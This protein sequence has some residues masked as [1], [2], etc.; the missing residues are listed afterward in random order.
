MDGT[1]EINATNSSWCQCRLILESQK[2]SL[3]AE[4]LLY[5]TSHLLSALEK[6][7]QGYTGEWRGHKVKWVLTLADQHST[8]Y[9]ASEGEHLILL[10]Q[11]STTELIASL[12]L[13]VDDCALWR[14]EIQ[15]LY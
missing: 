14:T 5:I 8:L 10:W 13:S 6:P 12:R 7:E 15:S 4:S 11:A 2:I 1:L 3:G 9:V